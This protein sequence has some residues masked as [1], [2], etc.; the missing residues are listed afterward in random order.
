VC[1]TLLAWPAAARADKPVIT[2]LY[3]DNDTGNAAF[4]HL[5]KGLADMMTTDLSA[6]PNIRVVEREKLQSLLDELKLQ[7]TSYFDPSTAQR[8]GRG[9]GAAFAVTGAFHA[10][11]P[12][13]RIDTRVVRIAT[14]EIVKAA[15]VTG[16]QDAFLALQGKLAATLVEG[17]EA[18]LAEPLAAPV[19][20]TLAKGKGTR[21]KTVDVAVD[22][23][24]ALATRDTGDL[25]AA[26]QQMQ[27]VIQKAPEFGLARTRYLEFM[28]R[29][30]VVK[31][32]VQKQAAD[33]D[34]PDERALL[35]R[36]EA[37][38]AA[39]PSPMP[40]RGSASDHYDRVCKYLSHR[41][42]RGIYLRRKVRQMLAQGP[43]AYL[44][45]VRAY[46]DN[47]LLYA[48]EARS[49]W[50]KDARPMISFIAHDSRRGAYSWV[51]GIY[52]ALAYTYQGALRPDSIPLNLGAF[53]VHYNSASEDEIEREHLDR[54]RTG[55]ARSKADTWG[56]PRPRAD[57]CFVQDDPSLADE[58]LRLTDALAG[59]ES[60]HWTEL[61]RAVD[62]LL[63]LGRA[64][65]AVAKLQRRLDR[66]PADVDYI[67]KKMRAILEGRAKGHTC[68]PPAAPASRPRASDPRSRAQPTRPRVLVAPSPGAP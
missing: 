1:A 22:Y 10:F 44:P 29:I 24:D 2:V 6:V 3:F 8:I 36:I 15:R 31:E 62:V 37:T 32:Q 25:K 4:K 33:Q 54:R 61:D 63:T 45:W 7:K 43:A 17:L 65:D 47:E 67:E 64:D 53:L 59:H 49:Y 39:K 40:D 27:R 48:A 52:G 13:V 56:K 23:G 9:V 46:R 5:G 34:E 51:P 38:L 60:G 28:K 18:A 50:R 21:A 14:G 66:S 68:E 58:A 41:V 16:T 12:E 35:Q 42:L 26:S 20:D 57:W 11:A 30:Y 19:K 55:P